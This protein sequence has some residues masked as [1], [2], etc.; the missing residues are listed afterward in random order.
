MGDLDLDTRVE[1]SDGD[2]KAELSA[3][4]E[5][6]GP[7]GGYLAAVAMRAAASEARIPRP[8]A[9]SCHFLGVAR[10]AAVELRVVAAQR[11]RRAESLSVS[12]TQ[13]GRPILSG[14]LR[15]A[16]HGPGL[17]HDV[18][19][20]PD[21][22][23]PDELLGWPELFPDQPGPNYAFWNNLDGRPVDPE[24]RVGPPRATPPVT[25]QWNRFQPT[26][27]FADPF[28]DAARS[29]ILLD[30]M[31]WPAA[32]RPHV[33]PAYLA[34]NLDVSAWFHAPAHDE[35]WLLSD[36]ACPI[37]HSGLMGVTGRIWSRDRRLIASG[38][39]QLLCIPAPG[40]E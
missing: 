23:E 5:I 19:V 4:W 13:A 29:L 31:G 35:P 20:C 34:P 3:E 38:G 22:R 25:R 26:A 18:S 36:H 8:V 24:M 30:T 28:L 11:G 17:E 32:C 39:A 37:A 10:F 2:Y 14:M 40:A 7:N 27:T 1:G 21:V 15:T 12:M 33:E 6:W 9:F 16:S